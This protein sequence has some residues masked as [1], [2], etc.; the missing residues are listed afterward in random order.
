MI[1]SAV[2]RIVIGGNH[3]MVASATLVDAKTGKTIITNPKLSG[4]IGAAQ[5]WAGVAVEAVV[6]HSKD[7]DSAGRYANRV[8]G[9][10][11]NN[12]RSWLFKS[13]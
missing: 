7:P 13:Y 8:I 2:Q 5:G 9:A 3:I 6:E 12:F 10:Y 11:S 4:V 1:A